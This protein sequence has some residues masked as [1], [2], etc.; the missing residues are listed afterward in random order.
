MKNANEFIERYNSDEEFRNEVKAK[1]QALK[2]SGEENLFAAVVK[3]AESLGYAV[4]EDEVKSFRKAQSGELSDEL[5]D[6]TAGGFPIAG[7]FPRGC[8]S[9]S[10]SC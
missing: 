4:T 8:S 1:T 7:G 9:C 3:V 6:N 10:A 5:L 2:G